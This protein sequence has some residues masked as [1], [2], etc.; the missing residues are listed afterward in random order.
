MK[1]RALPAGAAARS[2]LA[3][4]SPAIDRARQVATEIGARPY[5]L[6]LVWGTWGGE[7]RGEGD[8]KEVARLQLLPTPRIEDPSFA[9]TPFSA[10]V[11]PVG[12]LR[13]SQISASYTQ[14]VLQGERL[15]NGQDFDLQHR[16]ND[17]FYELVL[18]DR[19]PA[20]NPERSRMRLLAGPTLMPTRVSWELQ[21]ERTS[22]DRANKQAARDRRGC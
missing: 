6:F 15:P 8:F 16:R 5:L 20:E 12:T 19:G 9:R 13:V 14:P 21:L 7:Q 17:F 2:V 1:P 10:G 4:I 18:D 3:R 11:L 22:E